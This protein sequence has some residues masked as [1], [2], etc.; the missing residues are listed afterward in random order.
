MQK[1]TAI[2]NFIIFIVILTGLII[3]FWE[4]IANIFSGADKTKDIIKNFGIFAPLVFI[5]LT[6][7]QVLFAPIPGQVSGVAGGYLFGIILGTIYSMTGVVIGSV[8]T[9]YLSRKFGRPFVERIVNKKI[10]KKFNKIVMKRGIPALFLI[11]LLPA[12][13]D[14]IINYIAGLTKIKMKTLTAILIIGRLPGFIVLS[15]VG[16]G[17]GSENI[18]F[19]VILLIIV[20]IVSVILFLNKNKLEKKM[21][22]LVKKWTR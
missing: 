10:L 3:L 12:F 11:Y 18:L 16:A 4:P 1:K 15:A 17:L 7:L 5:L 6:I 8:I 14:D 21:K 22:K 19:S 2:I 9:F 20:I 13:P